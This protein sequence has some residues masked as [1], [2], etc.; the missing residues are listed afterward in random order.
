MNLTVRERPARQAKSTVQVLR[1]FYSKPIAWGGALLVSGT[2][3]YLG[4]AAMFWLHAI[5]RQEHGPQIG[6]VQHWLLDSTLGFVALTPIIF[7]LLPATLWVQR[8]KTRRARL[9]LLSYVLI[10][11][12][13]FALITGPG[14]FLHN[15]LVGADTALANWATDVFGRDPSVASHAAHA[16]ENSPLSEGVLQVVVGIPLYSLLTFGAVTVVR[17]T[18]AMRRVRTS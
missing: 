7:L 13:L 2:L 16:K 8:Q 11:G 15:S 1:S 4:G 17:R 12:T 3:S 9:R 14:P 5:Y 18:G 10:V 6:H